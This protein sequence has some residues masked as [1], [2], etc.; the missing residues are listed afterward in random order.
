[1]RKTL[2]LFCTLL[3]TGGVSAQGLFSSNKTSFRITGENTVELLT[4]DKEAKE[5]KVPSTVTH[6]GK[7][8]TVTS[9]AQNAFRSSNATSVDIPGTV[10]KIGRDAFQYSNITSITFH[11]GLEEIGAYAFSSSKCT[12]L[13]IPA[14]VKRIGESAFFGSEGNPT[15]EQLTLHEGLKVIES[16][17]F[18]G[19]AIR[20][21][22]IPASVDSIIGTAFLFS[23]KLESL[24]L[25][26]GLKYIGKG[27]FNNST[28]VLKARNTTLKSVTFP[29]TLKAIDKEAFLKMPLESVTI[30]AGLE[31]LGEMAFSGTNIETI[32]VDA[33]NKNFHLVNGILYD[34]KDKVLYLAPVTGVGSVE[35]KK[36]CLGI[37]GGAFWGSDLTSIK[38]P[39]GLLA[40][41][42][43]AFQGTP[44]TSIQLPSTLT[45]LDEEAFA[46]TNIT[47]VTIPENL[48]YIEQAT[49]WG[50]KNLRKVTL[51]S[52]LQGI[53]VRAFYGCDDLAEVV[54][55][56]SVPMKLADAYEGEEIFTA[57]AKLYVPKGCKDAYCDASTKLYKATLGSYDNNWPTYFS[58]SYI[59][60]TDKGV[61]KPTIS[62]PNDGDAL[63]KYAYGSYSLVFDEPVT[64]VNHSP[65]VS[66]RPDDLVY[67]SVFDAEE[68]IWNI[69]TEAGNTVTIFGTDG[70]GWTVGFLPDAQKIYFLTIPAGI[71]KNA[72]GDENE[73]ITIWL[74]G[75]KELKDK[76]EEYLDIESVETTDSK[77]VA[78]YSIDG[79]LLSAP[80]KG[81]NIVKYA[82]G[83]TRKV[84]VK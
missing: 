72:A 31:S 80:V 82:D 6:D 75:S 35:V 18:Y 66:L 60:E 70:D 51:P 15:L 49:F 4:G 23:T 63:S 2:L 83:T 1:M 79:K 48:P 19:N 74:Y 44:L 84:I 42:Y 33:N 62:Y 41:G 14:T 34:S 56:G 59:I 26:E 61:L 57:S 20:N 40:I 52:G 24:T 76:T 29:S 17:A 54:C 10:K 46:Q 69:N 11:E 78:R 67:P 53:S 9:I 30:P 68:T 77:E 65:Q 16:G 71:V 27:A 28:T 38:L 73:Q 64:I 47:E 50:C 39:E 81:I 55:K 32:N 25:N 58:K 5:L 3:A 13:D 45:F 36:S 22:V 7:E 12:S 37:S 43:A 8:Y 21:L